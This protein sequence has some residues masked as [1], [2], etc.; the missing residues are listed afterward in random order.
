MKK[1]NLK[2]LEA[3]HRMQGG[4]YV[5]HLRALLGEIDLKLRVTDGVNFHRLQGSA[6]LLQ[7]LI[8]N[9]EKASETYSEAIAR[10]RG[11][12]EDNSALRF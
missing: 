11:G 8:E 2:L 12:M 7:T 9:I 5:E 10:E 3:M 6:N 1:P 4:A